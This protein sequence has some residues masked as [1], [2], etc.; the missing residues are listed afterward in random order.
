MT[1]A[2]NPSDLSWV[3]ER[4]PQ[5]AYDLLK[6][7]PSRAFLAGGFI[8]SVI[9]HERIND[10]DLFTT[11]VYEAQELAE[12][13][14]KT[15]KGGTHISRS[16]YAFNVHGTRPHFQV[17]HKWGYSDPEVLIQSFDF[18]IAQAVVWHDGTEFR[19]LCADTYYEDLAAKRLVY[20]SR[21]RDDDQPGGSLLRSY[22]FAARGYRMPLDSLAALLA[23]MGAKAAADTEQL[24]PDCLLRDMREED[25]LVSLNEQLVE[26]D[27]TTGRRALVDKPKPPVHDDDLPF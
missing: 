13:Y 9:A 22:K 8:R 17:I 15:G 21:V 24:S 20:T 18:T 10:L 23:R 11:N 19:S 1:R 26:V 7:S 4:L 16:E 2:L 5:A 12:H 3:V 25:W 27:P 14:L 6:T